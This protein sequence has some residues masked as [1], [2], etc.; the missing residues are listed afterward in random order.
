MMRLKQLIEG[1]DCLQTIGSTDVSIA[2]IQFDSRAV[3]EG[4]LF[5]AV[6]G[7]LT[8]GHLYI[9]KAIELGASAIICEDLPTEIDNSITYVQVSNSAI[10]LALV[11][12]K[13]YDHP[14]SKLKLVGITGTNGKTT[15]ATLLHKL[16]IELG[17]H[18]G[19]LSTIQ[20]LV[21]ETVIPSTHTTPN[22]LVLNQ[23]LARMVDEGCDYCFMEVS[24]HAV[25]QHRIDGLVFA[26][27]V[28]TNLSHD[29]LDFHQNFDNYIKAKKTFFDQLPKHSFA[30]TNADDKNG[31]VM[32][33]NT[34]AFKKTYALKTLSDYKGKVLESHFSGMLMNIDGNELW[35]RLVGNFNAYNI[36]AVYGTALLL[37]QDHAKVL[38]VLSRI[39]GAAGRFETIISPTGIIGIIDYAHTPDALE[40]VLKTIVNL[41]QETSQIIT[42]IGCGGDRDKTKRPEMAEVAVR[43]SD[44]AIL[45]S[46]NPRTEEP[47]AILK[48]MESGIPVNK[49]R[50]YF[51]IADRREAIRAACHLALSGDIVLVAGKGHETYQEIKGVRY[52]FD[53]K[54]ILIESFNEE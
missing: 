11:A 22:P 17:Y 1:L 3:A 19:L 50:K 24:S 37:E 47:L 10:S 38:M 52:A 9:D 48:D 44:K 14:S 30:L 29:H 41:R 20:N 2:K 16:F 23:L 25:V 18:V 28:F 5:V 36:L 54:K 15:V 34:A 26:G 51:T 49:R 4:A 46:D 8:N 6:K 43:L 53:D 39:N 31:M 21:G 7:T 40:N 32:L 33:Q 12:S 42:V 27:G 35:V 45:T 13:F